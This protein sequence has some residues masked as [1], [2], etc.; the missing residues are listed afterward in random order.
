MYVFRWRSSSLR[1]FILA[2][3]RRSELLVN[4]S[5][6]RV[7]FHDSVFNIV[8]INIVNIVNFIGLASFKAACTCLSWYPFLKANASKKQQI[9]TTWGPLLQ[10]ELKSTLLSF[11]E[12]EKTRWHN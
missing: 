11:R 3:R 5:H 7:M 1:K 2:D 9:A 8:N 12:L 4:L 6:G 10:Y